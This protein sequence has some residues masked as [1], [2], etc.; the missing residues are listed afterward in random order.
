MPVP[1]PCPR[2]HRRRRRRRLRIRLQLQPR[3]HWHW[4]CLRLRLRLRR[5]RSWRRL[6]LRPSWLRLL[7]VG[8]EPSSELRVIADV[9]LAQVTRATDSQWY[10]YTAGG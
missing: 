2:P 9:T 10:G 1:R 5:C 4:H 8:V 3:W 7:I 6:W